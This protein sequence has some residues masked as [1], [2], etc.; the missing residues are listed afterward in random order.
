MIAKS[1]D[2]LHQ[3]SEQLSNEI[4]S[5]E[6]KLTPL[7]AEIQRSKEELELVLGLIRLRESDDQ[8][9]PFAAVQ[10]NGANTN[11]SDDHVTGGLEQEVEK[12]L[13]AS[14]KPMHIGA[15]A[16]C[17][18]DAGVVIPGKGQEANI[19]VRLRRSSDRFTRTARGV[20]GISDWG[21][22]EMPVRKRRR[23]RRRSK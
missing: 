14:G 5:I 13:K 1:L 7:R 8:E 22:K 16:E 2:E 23:R 18:R 4:I 15:I 20:Y 12:I 19:I 9:S 17:L 3:W 11:V 10:K 6:G 21:L